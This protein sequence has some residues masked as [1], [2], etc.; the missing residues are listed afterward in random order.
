MELSSL[1]SSFVPSFSPFVS[2]SVPPSSFVFH[3]LADDEDNEKWKKDPSDE[4]W[5]ACYNGEEKKVKLLS[6]K[7]NF[8]NNFILLNETFVSATNGN[9]IQI[10]KWMLKK[11]PNL[12]KNLTEENISGCFFAACIQGRLEMCRWLFYNFE[13][14][15]DKTSCLYYSFVFN[16]NKIVDFL[17]QEAN[18]D[19]EDLE[20]YEKSPIGEFV[21]NA[22]MILLKE[23]CKNAT[24]FGSFTK[25][26]K[27]N[28]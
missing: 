10:C 25:P 16:K 12:H 22:L 6:K 3:D 23:K 13:L 21:D 28:E 15:S 1:S 7:N 20:K 2:S 11:Y 5:D 27:F 18:V 19:M 8:E 24:K 26:V 17:L 9:Y 14:S 4:F